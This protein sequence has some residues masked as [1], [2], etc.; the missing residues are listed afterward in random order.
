MPGFCKGPLPSSSSSLGREDAP[1]PRGW[2]GMGALCSCALAMQKS[3]HLAGDMHSVCCI[4]FGQALLVVYSFGNRAY[5]IME[6]YA[7]LWVLL[8]CH[9]AWEPP[10]AHA[11]TQHAHLR[12]SCSSGATCSLLAVPWLGM[13]LAARHSGVQL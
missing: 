1:I 5:L 7:F 13:S 12:L 10:R 6:S 3:F 8:F 4:S 2:V 9:S 11:G